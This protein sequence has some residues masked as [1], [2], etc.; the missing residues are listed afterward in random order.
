MGTSK[1]YSA[2][3]SWG[4][5]KSEVTVAARTGAAPAQTAGRILGHFIQQNG[6]AGRMAHGGGSGGTIGGA[7]GRAVAQRLGG[8]ISAVGDVGLA[9]ALRREGL[10]ELIGR[11]IR[12]VLAGLLDKL[13][14]SASTIDDV[15]ARTALAALQDEYLAEA[16]DAAEVERILQGL[17]PDL[18]DVLGRYF[19][20]YLY[21][22]FC[23]VFFERL[24]QRVGEPKA[25]SFLKD[26]Q[27]FIVASLAN[28]L[29]SRSVAGVDW[30][31]PEGSRLCADIMQATLD[32]FTS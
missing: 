9:E 23:R 12:E 8:F 29:G 4:P 24:V 20:F 3:G 2:P 27:A 10:S 22:Q 14:G 31:G 30:K 21:E 15:D 32:V 17:V 5:L 7:S 16:V 6:G 26:I 1:G 25:L 19:G 18:D 11:P 13:G 28:R